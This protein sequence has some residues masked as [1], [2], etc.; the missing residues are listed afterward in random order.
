LTKH[1]VF[2]RADGNATIGLG[3]VIRGLSLAEMLN[4]TFDCVFVTVEP[5]EAIKAMI[6]P[7]A[8]LH[9]LRSAKDMT[10]LEKINAKS[11]VVLVDGYHFDAE[12]QQHIKQFG[13]KMVMIDDNA[14]VQYY[15]DLIINHGSSTIVSKYRK[16][17]YTRILTGF[18][19]LILRKT[20]LNEA[21]KSRQ[22]ANVDTAL[23]CMGGADPKKLTPKY[24][25]AVL[26]S[27]LFAKVNVVLGGANE[28]R[29]ENLFD[30]DNYTNVAV[31]RNIKDIEL[32]DL[33]LESQIVICPASTISLEVCCVKAGLLTGT[34][35]NNQEN[36]L[37]QLIDHN[38][39]S[40]IGNL[41]LASEENIILALT[42]L[43][44]VAKINSMMRN[45]QISIDG[46][47]DSRVTEA[48]KV[49]LN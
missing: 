24:L 30:V 14:D 33:I 6:E 43:A 3:H 31:Y 9:S 39:C 13:F 48:I 29:L 18:D 5:T 10:W 44:T 22:I 15:A 28:V 20:F 16:E 47:S 19:Y 45:Q 4:D 37:R 27:G 11:D 35:V 7:F 40:T 34:M 23:I 49:L 25:L 46:N 2:I 12:Y 41:E 32:I 26:K 1:N 21:K 38:C 17:G 42:E 36:I 8:K